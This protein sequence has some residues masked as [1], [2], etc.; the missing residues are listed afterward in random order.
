MSVKR[1]EDKVQ[2]MKTMHFFKDHVEEV[3]EGF[4]TLQEV[5]NQVLNS[6]K[7]LK[8]LQM[9]L[10]I[11][12]LLNEGT[13]NGGVDAFKFESLSKLSQTKSAD[14]KTTVLDYIVETFISKGERDVL[15]LLTEFP[16]IQVS[17]CDLHVIISKP[18]LISFDC[19]CQESSRLSIG[20]LMS[21]MNSLRKDYNL[22]KTELTKMKNDQSS[23][24][25]TRSMAKKINNES[26]AED[27]RKALFAAITARASKKEEPAADPRQ[28]LFAAIKS[29]KQE[30]AEDTDESND[31]ADT[32]Y[33][34]GVKRLQDFLHQSKTVISLA[35][36][37]QDAAIRACTVCHFYLFFLYPAI[38]C[39]SYVFS[40][41]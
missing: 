17:G 37:D 19:H 41:S 5:C 12:N 30:Q 13:L 9:V 22:C 26:K 28:A 16:D 21:E 20:D 10:N 11:G 24:R 1:I 18:R 39:A 35:D 34:P 2:V 14:G 33:T 40:P 3:R 25:V 8:V 29:R 23:K 4:K 15:N 36:S 32:E 38:T 6:E 7:L 27:P 31:T